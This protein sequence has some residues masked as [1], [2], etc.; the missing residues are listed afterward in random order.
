MMDN[1]GDYLVTAQLQDNNCSTCDRSIS[2]QDLANVIRLSGQYELPFGAGKPLVNQGWLSKV[3]GGFTVGAFFTYDDGAP[4]AVSSPNFSNSFGGGT[5][6]RPNV[7]GISTH[8]SGGRTMKNG[9][10]YFNPAAFKETP[11]FQFG[12]A[13]RYLADVR[14]PGT[15]N[16]DM[17]A[18]RRL[19]FAEHYSVDFRM[20]FFNAFNRVQFAGPNTS[21]ASSSFGQIFLSQINTPRTIQAG[22]RLSF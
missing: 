22:L 1:V 17:L 8:V 18:A 9:S 5:S 7:T 21:I 4:V 20:E 15:K 2:Q 12:N 14:A 3:V 10:F 16:F 13:P 19:L 11:S 6:M